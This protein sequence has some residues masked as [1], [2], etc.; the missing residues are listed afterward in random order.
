[1]IFCNRSVKFNKADFVIIYLD[2]FV[3]AARDFRIAN[4]EILI[5]AH[6]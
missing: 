3:H 4:F 6:I 2:C 5:T 1:M